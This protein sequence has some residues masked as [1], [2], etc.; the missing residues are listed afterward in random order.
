MVM[1][2]ILLLIIVF[3]F[4]AAFASAQETTRVYCE[5]QQYNSLTGGLSTYVDLGLE[6]S[7]LN[8]TYT[9]LMDDKGNRFVSKIAAVNYLCSKGWTVFTFIGG[10]ET[11]KD[12]V[13][14]N[15][16]IT[17]KSQITEGLNVKIKN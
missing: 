7:S 8:G 5:M 11:D 4:C 16:D 10:N 2:L 6:K 15:K 1:P 12:R 17:D 3:V 9:T 13:I 14:F